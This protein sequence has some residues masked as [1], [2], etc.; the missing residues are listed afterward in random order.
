MISEWEGMDI[1][2]RYGRK[3]SI[4]QHENTVSVVSSWAVRKKT[5]IWYIRGIADGWIVPVSGRHGCRES[6]ACLW[7][8]TEVL[9]EGFGGGF[10]VEDVGGGEPGAAELGDAVAHLVELFGGVGV[11]IDDD[12]AAVLFGQAEI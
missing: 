5:V 2:G 8:G 1:V 12:F 11:G 9:E 3:K 7:S 10:G 4:C 6:K